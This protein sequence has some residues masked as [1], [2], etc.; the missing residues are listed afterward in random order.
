MKK[1]LLALLAVCALCLTGCG[2]F[3]NREYS[4]TSPHSAAYYEKADK[5]VL[6]AETYQDLVND[7]L[8]LVGNHAV[9]GTVWL[10]NYTQESDAADAAQRACREVQVETPLGAYAVDY[11]TYTV[12]E[13]THNYYEIQLTLS[14]RRTKAQVGGIVNTTTASAISD[15]LTAAAGSG[16]SELVVRVAYFSGEQDSVRTAVAK[17]QSASG[18]GTEEPWAVHFYPDTDA[19]GIIEI[20]LKNAQNGVDK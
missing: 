9:K 18:H 14:Y 7:V 20:L 3:L 12:K 16:A 17:V 13:G 5:S 4:D 15:L 6:R 19:A 11:I 2:S 1:R 10:Y 8:I